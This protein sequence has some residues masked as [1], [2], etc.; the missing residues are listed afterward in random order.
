MEAALVTGTE[1]RR[2]RQSECSA[3]APAPITEEGFFVLSV[4]WGP[5][6]STQV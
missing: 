5:R 3:P 2:A 6:V 4:G 1:A